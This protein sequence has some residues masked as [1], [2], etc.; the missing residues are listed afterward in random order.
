MLLASSEEHHEL[1]DRKM[2][3]FHRGNL[4]SLMCPHGLETEGC[5]KKIL[6]LNTRPPCNVKLRLRVRYWTCTGT[7]YTF[8]FGA[9]STA[10]LHPPFLNPANRFNAWTLWLQSHTET[11]K[12]NLGFCLV[13]CAGKFSTCARVQREQQQQLRYLPLFQP[14]RSCS[15]CSR[16]LLAVAEWNRLCK[17]P[18]RL[19]ASL[20]LTLSL[21]QT[22]SAYVGIMKP[23]VLIKTACICHMCNPAK[24]CPVVVQ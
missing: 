11:S 16:V 21:F 14:Y 9:S 12:W 23:I 3:Y 15:V 5:F 24:S 1:T 4:V 10:S 6:V 22:S 20:P 2:D 13:K 7:S 8:K 19:T 17:S 18:Q